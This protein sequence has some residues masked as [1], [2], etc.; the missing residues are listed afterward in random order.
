[1]LLLLVPV[2]DTDLIKKAIL[3]LVPV[4]LSVP[5]PSLIFLPKVAM[6]IT[7]ICQAKDIQ[8]G[9]QDLVTKAR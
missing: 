9:P 2:A 4:D 6:A 5:H 8:A 3:P 1:L 7:G